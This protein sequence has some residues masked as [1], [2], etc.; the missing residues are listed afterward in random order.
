MGTND[1]TDLTVTFTTLRP[2]ASTLGPMIE[3][4]RD[5]RDALGQELV[6]S[7][8]TMDQS[9]ISVELLFRVKEG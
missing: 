1:M 5:R 3:A 7:R 9:E 4:E 8:Y 2:A 6:R